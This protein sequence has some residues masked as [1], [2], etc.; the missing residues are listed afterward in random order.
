MTMI[1]LRANRDLLALAQELERG[2]GER[3][4]GVIART[5]P[6]VDYL[7]D[8]ALQCY[9]SRDVLTGKS[10]GFVTNGSFLSFYGG[11]RNELRERPMLAHLERIAGRVKYLVPSLDP[12]DR[13]FDSIRYWRGPVWAVMNYMIGTGLAD[14]GHKSWGERIRSDSRALIEGAA[15]T[16][17]SV[18]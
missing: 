7:W 3:A 15:S 17:P 18:R 8:E 4:A 13:G 5:E 1:L 2:R 10:S 12:E 6:G 11:V 14:A 16:N 9:C